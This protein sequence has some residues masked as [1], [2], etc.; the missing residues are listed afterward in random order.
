[1]AP[2]RKIYRAQWVTDFLQY[3]VNSTATSICVVVCHTKECFLDNI[4]T[5]VRS[6]SGGAS[7]SFQ[8]F[9]KSIG[10]LSKSSQIKVIFCPTLEHLRAYLSVLQST[11]DLIEGISAEGQPMSRPLVAILDLLALHLPTTEFS[12]Q[13][14]SRTLATAAEVTTREGMDLVL[15]ECQNA[16][17]TPDA[18]SGDTL[19]NAEVPL[20]NTSVRIGGRTVSVRRVA[21]RWFEFDETM[22]ENSYT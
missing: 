6:S 1:M 10:L 11:N 7:E 18:D 17:D 16:T 20:L 22:N 19:W 14:L 9:T 21:E 8:L 5:S 13:G 4:S 2:I 12:A 3:V 15:C